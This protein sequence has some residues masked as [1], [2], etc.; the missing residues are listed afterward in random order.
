MLEIYEIV[1]G[2]QGTYLKKT[3]WNGHFNQELTELAG[4][5][6]IGEK[7]GKYVVRR[8]TYRFSDSTKPLNPV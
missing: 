8:K 3:D 5:E 1:D 6:I 2:K 4:L 7:N